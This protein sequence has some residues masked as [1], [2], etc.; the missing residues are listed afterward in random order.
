[1]RRNS[2]ELRRCRGHDNLNVG[3]EPE[4][5]PIVRIPVGRYLNQVTKVSE[6]SCQGRAPESDVLP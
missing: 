6:R 5:I 4:L 2:W 3:A 1:M